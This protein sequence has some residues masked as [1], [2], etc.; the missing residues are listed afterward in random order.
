[1]ANATLSP[2]SRRGGAYGGK[3]AL[4]TLGRANQSA[5]PSQ[6]EEAL[7]IARRLL[8]AGADPNR[9]AAID[10]FLLLPVPLTKTLSGASGAGLT[11]SYDV[12]S[13]KL[14]LEER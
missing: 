9:A 13:G 14:T 12:D 5:P 10:G 11:L 6:V 8:D 7:A 3:A 2:E 4:L 1:M